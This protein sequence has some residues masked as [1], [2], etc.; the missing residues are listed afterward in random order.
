MFLAALTSRSWVSPH[1]GHLHC[2]TDRS[3]VPVFRCPQ[4]EQNWLYGKTDN[5]ITTC[6]PYH[7]ALYSNCR[8]SD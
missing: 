4:Q 3:F 1:T 2:R 8:N 6:L 7:F 5:T